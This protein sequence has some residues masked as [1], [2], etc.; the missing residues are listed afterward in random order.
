MTAVVDAS[1]AFRWYVAALGSKPAWDL[2]QQQQGL[3]APELIVA[4]VANA[5]CK[6]VRAGQIGVAQARAMIGSLPQVLER[7]VPL[8]EL[9][10]RAFE[11]ACEF[12]H[13]V[14]DCFYVALAEREKVAL[15][16]AD[17][18]LISRLRRARWRGQ[19]RPLQSKPV[20]R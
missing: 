16:T 11:I 3:I 7:I 19:I 17:E 12:E 9:S 18:K 6:V 4:E 1:I 10:D 20:R 15:I 5:A 2:L 14:Y 8:D 13:P